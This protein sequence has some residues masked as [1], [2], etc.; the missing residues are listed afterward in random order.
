MKKLDLFF[1]TILVPL[2]YVAL[3]L[4]S[5]AAYFLRFTEYFRVVRPVIFKL[6]F[7]QYVRASALV[8]LGWLIV[9]TSGKD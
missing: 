1:A 2:D 7:D 4:A 3:M 6:P 9:L 8:A 5:V